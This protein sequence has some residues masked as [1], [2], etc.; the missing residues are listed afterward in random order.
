LGLSIVKHIVELH[1]GEVS[2]QSELDQGTTFSFSL[3]CEC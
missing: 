3:P 1:G 2:V